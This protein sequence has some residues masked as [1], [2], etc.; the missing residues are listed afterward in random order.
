MSGGFGQLARWQGEY[1]FPTRRPI[2][3]TGYV[4]RRYVLPKFLKF[5]AS[6]LPPRGDATDAN[7]ERFAQQIRKLSN[8]THKTAPGLI[9]LYPTE[10]ELAA[11]RTGKAWM[12]ESTA[13]EAIARSNGLGIL[14]LA[15]VPEWKTSLYRDGIHPTIEGNRILAGI[16]A[17]AIT[18]G[19]DIRRK[20]P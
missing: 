19:M 13:L 2:W 9:L 12:P 10:A 18:R 3:A 5:D 11:A 17:T 4:L 6:E 1:T 16:L 20:L 14:D 15:K 8:A 7:F